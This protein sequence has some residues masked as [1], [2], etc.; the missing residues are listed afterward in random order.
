MKNLVFNKKTLQA[1][2][3]GVIFLTSVFY[4][5]NSA[6]AQN[7]SSNYD[8]TVSPVFFDLTSNPGDTLS[9][10]IK[11]RN[12]TSS[13]IAIILQV[14]GISGDLNG[15]LTLK[16]DKLNQA[17][18]WVNFQDTKETLKPLEW[19]EI[20]FTIQVPKDA[21]YGYY[22]AVSFTQDKQSTLKNTG[23]SITGAAAVPILLNVRKPGA[24][25]DAK[26][27]N[28]S[29][30]NY[31]NEYLPINFNTK[32]QNTGNIHVKPHGNIFISTGNNKNIAILDVNGG[33]GSIL[34]QSARIFQSSWSDG[35]IVNQ[36]II[37][38][39]QPKLDKNGKIQTHL[40]V[41][42]NKLTSFRFGKYT[43][44]LLLVFDN[45]KRDV[46]LET[47]VSFW[48]IPYKVIIGVIISVILLII[49]IRFLL[50]YY[51]N[52]QIKKRLGT[53]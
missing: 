37:E 21:A 17:V 24:K 20:P 5:L 36:P 34:P 3:I 7:S 47:S 23:A 38:N 10:K 41:S 26:I 14:K 19:T 30:D 13:P 35:F 2:I 53:S 42:W 32:I 18:N 49:I 48:V 6:F 45:G 22:V 12:N 11:I 31:V 46:P 4:I 33:L 44:N 39:G 28:F 9:E 1:I 15:N 52:R 43:A 8:V 51:I 25:S 40:V 16:E 29:V 50:K 27:L